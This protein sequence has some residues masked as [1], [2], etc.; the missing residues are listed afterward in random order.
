MS[1]TLSIPVKE[2]GFRPAWIVDGQQ[3]AI[4]LK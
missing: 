4:A 1:G 2:E 3:R